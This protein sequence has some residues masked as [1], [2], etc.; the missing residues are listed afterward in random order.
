MA[1]RYTPNLVELLVAIAIIG[2]L[3]ALLLSA[4]QSARY[5]AR[6]S[7]LVTGEY[8]APASAALS[9]DSMRSKTEAKL[10]NY[11]DVMNEPR[12]II[13]E[14]EISLVVDDVSGTEA[15]VAKLL[16]QFGGYVAES[17]VDRTQGEQLSGRWQVRVPVEQFNPF[18]EA[19]SKL[20]VVENR[21]QTAQDVTEEFVDLE[22]QIGNKKRLE[23]RI[24]EL[25]KN[26][27]G[28]IKDVIEV[29]RELARVRGEIEQME[30]RLR[31]LTNRT[32]LTTVTID[33]RE[34]DDYVPPQALSFV[35]RISQA[36]RGSL[37]ALRVFGERVTVAFV[38][39]F[40]W[41]VIL[42]ALVGP[43]WWY[44]GKRNAAKRNPANE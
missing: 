36:W 12:K 14:A 7:S 6:N 13:Y 34:V 23:E 38:Y 9:Q 2:T 25:L 41:I 33:A 17:K 10:V 20:G 29:E 24:L 31:Y 26:S 44:V 19:V 37:L 16:Q 21:H 32:D 42:S 30:G 15:Q 22:A 1:H 3:I 11:Q 4:T 28:A 5:A 39:A 18:L 40:P 43:P 8:D 35:E 27:E